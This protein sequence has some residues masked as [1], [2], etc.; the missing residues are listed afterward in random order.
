M[1]RINEGFEKNTDVELSVSAARSSRFKADALEYEAS[2]RD[3]YVSEMF[4]INSMKELFNIKNE[5]EYKRINKDIVEAIGEGIS[6]HGSDVLED[7][8][9]HG[10]LGFRQ[11]Y[12]DSIKNAFATRGLNGVSE[13]IANAYSFFLVYTIVSERAKDLRDNSS[14]ELKR[15][16]TDSV[17]V[18]SYNI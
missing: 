15:M 2:L 13:T 10:G 4:G 1:G 5:E 17:S 3:H 12:N 18:P 7:V 8:I 9:L 6:E 11:M 16:R 14:R